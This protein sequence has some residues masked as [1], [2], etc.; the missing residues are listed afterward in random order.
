M[1]RILALNYRLEVHSR[2][3]YGMLAS[4]GHE[5]W[6]FPLFDPIDPGAPGVCSP[7]FHER[8]ALCRRPFVHRSEASGEQLF[9]TPDLSA[10]RGLIELRTLI[11][12]VIC[13]GLF[14]AATPALLAAAKLLG[15]PFVAQV[16]CRP[17]RNELMRSKPVRAL[18]R[19][20]LA[21]C[22]GVLAA[23]HV[24]VLHE[25]GVPERKIFRF[26][27]FIDFDLSGTRRPAE[28]EVGLSRGDGIRLG[29]VG[30]LFHLKGL[31][32][33]LDS[34]RELRARYRNLELL[35]IGG[36]PAEAQGAS[37][38]GE[39]RHRI[40]RWE[41]EGVTITGWLPR[42]EVQRHLASV[43]I[44]LFPS[45]ADTF[46]KAVMEA[47]ALGIP[48]ALSD[49]CG[50]V[51]TLAVDGETALV[52]P[53]RDVHSITT[54]VERLICE[55]EL[56]ARLGAA[57]RVR[58]LSRTPERACDIYEEAIRAATG[59]PRTACLADGVDQAPGLS[60]GRGTAT[61]E[62]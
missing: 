29:Y 52:F 19:A 2:V 1:A 39:L 4:R 7:L 51:G 8:P 23:G 11:D 37:C 40:S 58:M 5:I 3:V 10:M 46:P 45:H 57:G 62:P 22:D 55:P 59:H 33:L 54:C 42:R 34:F 26:D 49:A 30:Q 38:E 21:A 36:T 47:M 41:L 35:L 12:V 17:R 25:Y 16:F 15:I 48:V 56:R 61:G 9:F 32:E 53:A 13:H 43:D 50:S 44:F 6:H 20:Y 27:P 24:E 60:S 28:S 18:R 14:V 31:L